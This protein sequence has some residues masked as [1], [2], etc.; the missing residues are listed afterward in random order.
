MMSQKERLNSLGKFKAEIVRVLIA[1][2][3]GSR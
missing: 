2:D 3:V 1:T